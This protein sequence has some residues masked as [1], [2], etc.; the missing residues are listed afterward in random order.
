MHFLI[1]TKSWSSAWNRLSTVSKLN[2][3]IS[4]RVLSEFLFTFRFDF[5]DYLIELVLRGLNFWDFLVAFQIVFLIVFF[6]F[7][8]LYLHYVFAGASYRKQIIVIFPN[9]TQVMEYI[10]DF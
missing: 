2:Q 4:Q 6:E 9:I 8:I 3:V 5:P 10:V 1:Q 7:W